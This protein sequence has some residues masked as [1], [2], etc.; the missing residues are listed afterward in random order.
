MV[1]SGLLHLVRPEPYAR[2]VPRPLGSP[3]PY[4]FWSGIAELIAG[5]LLLSPRTRSWGGKL[6][7]ALLVVVFPA[8]VKMALD[9]AVPGGNWF[10]GSD[11]LLWLRLP[12]QPLLVWWAWSF[13]RD[14]GG[15]PARPLTRSKPTT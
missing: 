3:E 8:N 10:T 5:S 14:S 1:G 6:T 11:L 2:I 4:V 7:A 15:T 9:G 12:L 13:A